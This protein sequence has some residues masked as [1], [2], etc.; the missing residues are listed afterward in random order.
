LPACPAQAGAVITAVTTWP[1]AHCHSVA[2]RAGKVS[3]TWLR[4]K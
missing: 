3:L 2:P 1:R 4:A